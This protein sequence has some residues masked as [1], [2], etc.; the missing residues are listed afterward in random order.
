M[1]ITAL[2]TLL[3]STSVP[4]AAQDSKA[5]SPPVLTGQIG[6]LV[7]DVPRY[8]G[9][10]QRWMLPVPLV[11]L[12]LG[13]RFYLGGGP[14]SLSAG[15]GLILFESRRMTW[16]ADLALTPDRPEDRSGALAGMEDRGFGVFGGSTLTYRMG[17]AA[18]TGGVAVGLEDRMGMLGFIGLSVGGRLGARWFGQLG[19]A[20][21]FSSCE[22]MAWDFGITEGQ[23]ERRGEL[24]AGGAPGLRPG[25]DVPYRPDCGLRE[26]RAHGNLG[27]A[28][29][30]R[31]SGMAMLTG[32]RLE[33]GAARS[34]LTRERNTWEA[35]LG[36]AW[37]F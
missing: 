11:D 13:D 6:I 25:D 9:S 12:R 7:L 23:A 26:L 35:G 14:S 1:R 15:A 17:P 8:P 32:I 4:C 2:L 21:V 36:L 20:G 24:L 37:R 34:P 18:A 3:I 5:G 16:T 19:S 31:L 33:G 10:D 28:L 22:N 30:Q 29:S 27:Y